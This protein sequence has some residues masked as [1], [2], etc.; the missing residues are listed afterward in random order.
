MRWKIKDTYRWFALVPRKMDDGTW[1]LLESYYTH[2]VDFGWTKSYSRD[3]DNIW[4]QDVYQSLGEEKTTS[5]PM[6]E[7][8]ESSATTTERFFSWK[9]VQSLLEDIRRKLDKLEN[10]PV[11]QTSQWNGTAP[12][13]NVTTSNTPTDL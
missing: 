10:P 7:D 4:N 6:A 9:E 11:I 13:L 2:S 3:L 8:I 12:D 5:D 1:V